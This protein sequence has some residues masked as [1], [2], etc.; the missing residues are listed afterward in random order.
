MKLNLPI[1]KIILI[2]VLLLSFNL[3][4]SSAQTV[5]G[6]ATLFE[7]DAAGN[8]VERRTEPFTIISPKPGKDNEEEKVDTLTQEFDKNIMHR[9]E[10]IVIKAYP[11]P[12][13]NMLIIENLSWN[14]K[15]NITIMLFDVAGKHIL[16]KSTH[17]AKE[18]I[19]FS[20]V[21]PGTYQVHYYLDNKLLTNWKIIKN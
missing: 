6:M 3:Q 7:Y 15:N 10:G 4:K 17:S 16:T 14:E 20:S 8:R 9:N 18:Q 2:V 5:M 19:P 13:S 21:A 11:N 12:V 1:T